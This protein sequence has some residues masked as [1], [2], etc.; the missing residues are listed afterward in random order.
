MS[1]IIISSLQLPNCHIGRL[2]VADSAFKCYTLEL[3][4]HNNAKNISAIPAGVYKYE[5]RFSPSL[6]MHVI[7]LTD[8]K[9]RTW[10]YIHAGNF[11]SQIE[12]CILVG[13]GVKDINRDGVSDVTN[14]ADTFKQLMN[15]IEPTG[16][17]RV[18]RGVPL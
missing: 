8:V 12:G 9:G 7:H 2:E 5:I 16:T 14:S 4:W 6:K 18:K 1:E 11:T 13:D 15:L 10:I 3:P 17:V